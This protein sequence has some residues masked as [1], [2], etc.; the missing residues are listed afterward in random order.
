MNM[1][2]EF[3]TSERELYLDKKGSSTSNL[4]KYNTI[5]IELSL[6]NYET[7][8]QW[9]IGPTDLTESITS[10]L[11]SQEVSHFK[12]LDIWQLH[13]LP[14]NITEVSRGIMGGEFNYI[15]SIQAEQKVWWKCWM[16]PVASQ[17]CKAFF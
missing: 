14:H 4:H 7:V 16:Y 10:C 17:F 1:L 11:H 2:E 12:L 3:D 13:F 9:L 15:F 5:T 8:F 6:T